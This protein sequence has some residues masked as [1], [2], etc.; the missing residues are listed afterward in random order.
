[1]KVAGTVEKMV[2][3]TGI[4][5]SLRVLGL[6]LAWKHKA[7]T[8]THALFNV[9]EVKD[10]DCVM[11]RFG[12]NQMKLLL[13]VAA[14]LFAFPIYAYDENDLKRFKALN[15]CPGC[16]LSGADFTRRDFSYAQRRS[17]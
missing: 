17:H 5:L 11:T 2:G 12:V 16:E 6:L 14:L 8:H 13:F 15:K 1:M 4:E 3:A 9:W 10:Y 7:C